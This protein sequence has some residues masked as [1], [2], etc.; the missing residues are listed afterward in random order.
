VQLLPTTISHTIRQFQDPKDTFICQGMFRVYG[1]L[2]AKSILLWWIPK[3]Q[4]ECQNIADLGDGGEIAG[5]F[6]SSTGKLVESS[7]ARN[8][9]QAS[10]FAVGPIHLRF[11]DDP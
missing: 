8:W 10:G 9:I 3:A 7:F 2:V 4:G 5:V 6:R 11:G 1:G